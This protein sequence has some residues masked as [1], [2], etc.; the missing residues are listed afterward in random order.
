MPSANSLTA[1]AF[2]NNPR[3][4]NRS[5]VWFFDVNLYLS[6]TGED[7]ESICGA[8]RCFN[9]KD[10]P[11]DNENAGVYLIHAW[12]GLPN[13]V[14]DLGANATG[15]YD[16]V[17]DIQW[18]ILL[19]EHT[20]GENAD[21]APTV[22]LPKIDLEY[23]PYLSLSGLPFN[24]DKP[25]A[26]FDMDIEQYTQISKG[27]PVTV[28][29]ASCSIIDS[30]RWAKPALGAYA[31]NRTYQTD[32]FPRFI[33]STPPFRTDSEYTSASVS[34]DKRGCGLSPFNSISY[35]NSVSVYRENNSVSVFNPYGP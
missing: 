30:P 20:Y 4:V 21:D 22:R 17:G 35:S 28:F 15:E 19:H 2:L 7:A 29:P 13:D 26:K 14:C 25:Q 6:G 5:K 16:L 8:C 27:G 3:Q 34:L 12:V 10:L 24:I 1:I 33:N 23:R 11:F 32:T 31:G 9:D 18:L